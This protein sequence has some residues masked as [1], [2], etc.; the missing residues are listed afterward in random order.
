VSRNDVIMGAAALVL[1][2]FSLVV[3][4]V[5][6]RRDPGFPGRNLK[7]LVAVAALLVVAMLVAVEI[8]GESH[9]GE[10]RTEAAETTE[11][12]TA[13]P[14]GEAEAGIPPEADAAAGADV[15][16]S[17]G[18]GT[19]HVLESAGSTGAIGPSLD[20]STM[21]FDAVVQQVANGGGG[22]PAFSGQLSEDEIRDVSAF[23]VSARGS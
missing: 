9:A 14:E 3:S 20:D 13:P 21:E 12:E 17:A 10:E 19:C 2:V 4:L 18:C 8:F 6:P 15:Y 5:I 23:V 22:M 1:V 11:G 7:A 16:E